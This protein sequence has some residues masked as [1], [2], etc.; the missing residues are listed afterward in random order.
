MDKLFFE[1]N[2]KEELQAENFS[3]GGASAILLA[4]SLLCISLLF[5]N[6]SFSLKRG[7]SDNL[8]KIED[9]LLTLADTLEEN[10]AVCAF[11]GIEDDLPKEDEI[12]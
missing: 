8:N 10:E 1:L 9:A 12:Y 2:K 7:E 11:L 6:L 3:S 5:F 4:L